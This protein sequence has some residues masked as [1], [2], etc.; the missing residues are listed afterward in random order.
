MQFKFFK[1]V[2][3][4]S[5]FFMDYKAKSGVIIFCHGIV[6]SEFNENRGEYY[7]GNI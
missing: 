3:T 1:W 5:V 2:G 4:L 6:F 7:V